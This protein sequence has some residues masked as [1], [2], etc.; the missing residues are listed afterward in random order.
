MTQD[1]RFGDLGTSIIIIFKDIG[2]NIIDLSQN[3]LLTITFID[4]DSIE[5]GPFNMSLVT[6]GRDGQAVYVTSLTNSLWNKR[7]TWSWFGTCK[8]PRGQFGT[9]SAFHKVI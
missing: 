9:N 8:I 4:P 6:D 2:G 1:I 3:T 5:V 7:K